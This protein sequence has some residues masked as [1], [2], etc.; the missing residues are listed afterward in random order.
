M[1]YATRLDLVDRFGERELVQLT[2]R[3]NVP[4]TTV[5]DVAV[6][7]ALAD[8]T[9]LID[10]YVGKVARLPLAPAPAHL[11]K[12]ACD[13][14]WYSLHGKRAD[15]DSPVTRAHGEA[16]AWLRDVA[17][18]RVRLD[19]AGATPPAPEGAA[20]RVSASEPVFTRDRLR[21]F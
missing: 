10:G 17:A 21:G 20:G 14:A 2:D 4:P 5:D 13:L 1:T 16:L 7:R 9:G 11:I 15:K 8:A 19:D 6:G 12:I 3:I 18:G